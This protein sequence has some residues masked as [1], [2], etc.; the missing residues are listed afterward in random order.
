MAE[1]KERLHAKLSASA[2]KRWLSCPG[3]VAL[4][5]GFPDSSSVYADE[6]TLAHELAEE[7]ITKQGRSGIGIKRKIRAFYEE[8]A[9]LGGTFEEMEEY[10]VPYFE[11]VVEEL[12]ALRRVD[13]GAILR[14]EERLDL[15]EW[16]PEG[17]GTSDVVLLGG[18]TLEIIDLKYGKGVPVEAEGNTQMRIYAL[19]AYALMSMLADIDTVRMVIYQP[20][21][22][23]ISVAEMPAEDL[24]KWG[25][26]VL[27]PG[28]QLALTKDA[29]RAAGD[30]CR[31]CPAKVRCRT[32]YEANM[33]IAQKRKEGLISQEEVAGVLSVADE[34][35]KW[36]EEVKAQALTDM[37]NGE[38]IPGFKVVEGRSNRKFNAPEETIVGMAEAAGFDEALLYERKLLSLTAIEKL[39]GKRRFAEEL[40]SIVEKPEGKPT[41]AP[42]SDKR[43]ALSKKKAVEDFDGEFGGETADE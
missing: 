40:G 25:E 18:N 37:L 43:P 33:A 34:V 3:S 17:F 30:H 15:T 11:W 36:L 21:L 24:L 22:D 31:F 19:G 29:P 28:A 41:I 35:A 26:D 38:K 16:I 39:M 4:S 8:H 7:L 6:G 9:D 12:N 23:D 2:S 27:K 5:E 32:R 14:T 10:I 1:H 42:E 20:R 13:A